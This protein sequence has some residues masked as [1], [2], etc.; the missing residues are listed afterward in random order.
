MSAPLG[1]G[2]HGLDGQRAACRGE[3]SDGCVRPHSPSRPGHLSVLILPSGVHCEP[4][5]NAGSRSKALRR[6]TS[7]RG[8]AV[9]SARHCS[10]QILAL[11]RFA[12]LSFAFAFCL[13]TSCFLL[14]FLSFLPPLSPI[15]KS[16][17]VVFGRCRL[18]RIGR[19][20]LPVGRLRYP[21][22]VAKCDRANAT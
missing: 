12:S 3:S 2:A 6:S 11:G 7:L 1:A 15:E 17:I 18:P 9:P 14:L 21:L 16:P 22:G 4:D 5:A 13:R 10:G 20:V 19:A 8:G